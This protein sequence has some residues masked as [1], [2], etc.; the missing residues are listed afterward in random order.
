MFWG[1]Y[2]ILEILNVPFY[3]MLVFVQLLIL[4]GG[5]ES[6]P[7]PK[8]AVEKSLLGSNHQGDQRFGDTARVQC[9]RDS[10][11]VL[12]WSQIKEVYGG[13]NLILTI[14]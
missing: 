5:V 8:Y 2:I 6:N 4:D 14:H 10:L 12:C 3:L 13:V 11:F 9:A 1:F 7:G